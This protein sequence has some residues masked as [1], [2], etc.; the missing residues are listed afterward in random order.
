[1][2]IN[3]VRWIEDHQRDGESASQRK[4]RRKRKKKGGNVGKKTANKG[5]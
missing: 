3:E 5:T 4:R 2:N 1:M